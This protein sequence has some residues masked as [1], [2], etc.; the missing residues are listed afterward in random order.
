MIIIDCPVCGHYKHRP[1]ACTGGM[2]DYCDCTYVSVISQNE[3]GGGTSPA[4]SSQR[5][6]GTSGDSKNS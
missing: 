3:T 1:R 2:G 6:S 5:G 4:E